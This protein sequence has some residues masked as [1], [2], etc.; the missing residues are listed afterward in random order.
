MVEVPGSCC[1]RHL[2]LDC[3][4]CCWLRQGPAQIMQQVGSSAGSPCVPCTRSTHPLTRPT[5]AP[6]LTCGGLA[7]AA[8]CCASS[9]C[10]SACCL[11]MC[12]L[13]LSLCLNTRSQK[14]QFSSWPRLSITEGPL[15]PPPPPDLQGVRQLV[16]ALHRIYCQLVLLLPPPPRSRKD[17]RLLP[18]LVP[19]FDAPHSAVTAAVLPAATTRRSCCSSGRPGMQFR[20]AC[21][22]EMPS[23]AQVESDLLLQSSLAS[24]SLLGP[25]SCSV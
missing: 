22:V 3:C 4:C 25:A 19:V 9:C 8:G 24:S 2:L 14:G 12:C 13:S 1:S 21:A 18:L 23:G 20:L 10:W 6:A 15:A 17:I 7:A 16:E 5:P 11:A